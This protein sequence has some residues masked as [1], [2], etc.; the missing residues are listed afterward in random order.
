MPLFASAQLIACRDSIKDGYNFWLYI[1]D[2]YN[3]TV[4]DKPVVLFLHG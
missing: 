1:P 2:D 4:A 3:D